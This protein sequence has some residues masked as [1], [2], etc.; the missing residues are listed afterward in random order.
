MIWC[1]LLL[2]VAV[3]EGVYAQATTSAPVAGTG[4]CTFAAVGFVIPLVLCN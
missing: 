2:L 3:I 1:G 4:G